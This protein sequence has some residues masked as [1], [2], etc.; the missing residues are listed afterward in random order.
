MIKFAF[1]GSSEFSLYVLG[2]LETKGFLPSVVVT[3]PDMPKGRGLVMTPTPVKS[4]AIANFIPVLDPETLDDDFVA[5]LKAY[6]CETF[7]VASYGKIIPEKVLDAAPKKTLNVHPSLLP[8]YRGASPI[9]N[10]ILDDAR[11][12]GVT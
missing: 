10:A 8:R 5:H 11:D 4:W 1:F 9:Q 12:T 3:T 6:G 7:I 2:A